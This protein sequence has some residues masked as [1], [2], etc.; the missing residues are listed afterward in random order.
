M[1]HLQVDLDTIVA[2][3]KRWEREAK[4]FRNDGWVQQGYVEKLKKIF[5][6]SGKA[7][8]EVKNDK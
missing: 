2:A 7:L 6:E 8:S 3:I 5:V 1:E 4:N